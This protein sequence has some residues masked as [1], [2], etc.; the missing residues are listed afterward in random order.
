[1]PSMKFRISSEFGVLEEIRNGRPHTGIDL[2]MPTG[3]DLRSIADGF[4]TKIVDQGA[5]GLG[6][7]VYV[8]TR[9][10]EVHIYGHM[11]DISVKQGEVVH[12][13]DLLGH[14][15][16]TGHSTGPHLH[17]AIKDHG[18]FVDPS[19]VIDN[20][21]KVSGPYKQSDY[22]LFDLIKEG[23][24]TIKAHI[25]DVIQESIQE[26][27]ISLGIFIYDSLQVVGLIAT[28]VCILI[29]VFGFPNGYKYAWVIG[30]VY[31]VSRVLGGALLR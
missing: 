18:Q 23:P 29:G 25:K 27:F 26:I 19:N 30:L 15:G 5:E 8:K 9:S 7:A 4:V 12:F 11:N 6:K 31:T 13:G 17:F 3:T 24:E 16:N 10:G 21:Q 14:S 1:M 2:A 28:A 20:L 22:S